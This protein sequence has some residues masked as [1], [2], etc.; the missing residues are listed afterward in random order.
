MSIKITVKIEIIF[1][2]CHLSDLPFELSYTKCPKG[3]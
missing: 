3:S 2:N 1:I